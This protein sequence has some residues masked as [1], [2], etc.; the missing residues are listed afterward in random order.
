[1]G[2]THIAIEANNILGDNPLWHATLSLQS[3]EQLHA[4]MDSME[5]MI[6]QPDIQAYV[7]YHT[8]DTTVMPVVDARIAFNRLSGHYTDMQA[9]IQASTLT[10]QLQAPRLKATLQSNQVAAQMPNVANISTQHI[11]I[12]AAAR[13]TPKE[14]TT[15]C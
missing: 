12:E 8:T 1:M 5:V 10:A 13:Y 6:D 4:A 9:D 3:A 7:A 2:N 14:A 11:S 15:Y